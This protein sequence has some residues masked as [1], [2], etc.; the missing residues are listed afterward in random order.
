MLDKQYRGYG[1]VESLRGPAL[2]PRCGKFLKSSLSLSLRTGE[3]D[4]HGDAESVR[5]RRPRPRPPLWIVPNKT[6]A[7][8]LSL[9]GSQALSQDLMPFTAGARSSVSWRIVVMRSP[10]AGAALED[11]PSW[12][13]PNNALSF[14]LCLRGPGPAAL[15]PKPPTSPGG[16]C[17]HFMDGHPHRFSTDFE[18]TL[19]GE[20][21]AR[22]GAGCARVPL[23]T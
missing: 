5:G 16:G 13:V 22:R 19:L 8:A 14:S 20:H 11:P 23:G 7:R 3:A 15:T 1:D 21:L 10:C 2:D 4:R 18:Q 9:S 12:I 6:R 17:T